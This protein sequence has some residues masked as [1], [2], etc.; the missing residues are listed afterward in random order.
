MIFVQLLKVWKLLLQKKIYKFKTNQFDALK[1]QLKENLSKDDFVLL[2]G[3][4]SM[5]L[6][7]L[8]SIL[9]EGEI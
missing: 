3:S 9:K 6:E 8:E 4:R 7:R 1:K 5:E 2:K